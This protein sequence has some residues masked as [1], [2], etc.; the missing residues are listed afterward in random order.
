M[1]SM[2]LSTPGRTERSERDSFMITITFTGRVPPSAE[3]AASAAS[4]GLSPARAANVS[5]E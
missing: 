3:A 4:L 1:A 2:L 5:W